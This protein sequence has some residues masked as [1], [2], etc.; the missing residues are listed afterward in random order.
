MI[1]NEK[2][3]NDKL[4]TL[5]TEIVDLP[6]IKDSQD[7][8]PDVEMVEEKPRIMM[9]NQSLGFNKAAEQE[10][11]DMA[12]N[13]G[14]YSSSILPTAK[15]EDDQALVTVSGVVSKIIFSPHFRMY[16]L[17]RLQRLSE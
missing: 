3:I 17:A 1:S 2:E 15:P 13:F 11:I 6:E 8:K 4:A 7:E 9:T 16:L 5:Q 12:L 14:Y 10:G